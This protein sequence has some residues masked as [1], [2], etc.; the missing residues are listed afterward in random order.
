VKQKLKVSPTAGILSAP[1]GNGVHAIFQPGS[2]SVRPHKPHEPLSIH[3]LF[4]KFVSF[5]VNS[6]ICL[7]YVRSNRKFVVVFSIRIR[8][9]NAMTR[10]G[11]R[12]R[13]GNR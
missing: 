13:C 1:P 4:V 7:P 6:S 3:N 12:K 2:P 10:T 11:G 8:R 5:V 9:K